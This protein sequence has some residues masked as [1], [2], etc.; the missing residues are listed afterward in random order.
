LRE[1]EAKTPE[2]VAVRFI[3]I[4]SQRKVNQFCAPLGGQ[5]LCVADPSKSSYEAM[6][7]ERYDL[8]RIF[9]D[10]ALKERRRENKRAGF[11]QNWAATKL[12]DAAQLPGAAV[13]DAQG[14]IRWLH[15]GIHP[16]DLPP[17]SQML[18]AAAAVLD[19][20]RGE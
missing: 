1:F 13:I 4:G 19:G 20:S 2:H 10:P 17:M 7:L 3:V 18:S 16:G 8:R 9:T 5:D 12:R 15:R 11:S 6:G 14:V